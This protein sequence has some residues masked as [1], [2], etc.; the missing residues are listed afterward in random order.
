MRERAEILK[1]GTKV[2]VR[3]IRPDDKDMLTAAFRKL[4]P[5]SVY[6]RFFQEKASHTLTAAGT[7]PS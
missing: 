6:M 4:D 3:R 1:N 7:R 5:E 2:R